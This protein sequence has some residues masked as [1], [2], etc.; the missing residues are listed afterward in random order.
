VEVVV[1]D[2]LVNE[3]VKSFVRTIGIDASAHHGNCHVYVMPLQEWP[4]I[5]NVDQTQQPVGSK[6]SLRSHRRD[7]FDLAQ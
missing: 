3:L 4:Q 6:D 1:D 7:V 2:T 5:P